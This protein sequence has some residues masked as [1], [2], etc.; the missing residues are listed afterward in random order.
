MYNYELEVL[1]TNIS[2]YPNP[3]N[4]ETTF[5]FSI[6]ENSKVDISIYNIKG[7]KIKTLVYNEFV[8]GNHYIIWKGDD[9]SGKLASSGVYLYQLMVN[10][11]TEAI[12][13]CLLLK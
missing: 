12:K 8:E 5:S 11:K 1:N 9:D 6:P 3:F 4:P 2:N 7:Q 13:R 10:G